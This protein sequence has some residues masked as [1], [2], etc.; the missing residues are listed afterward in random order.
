MNRMSFPGLQSPAP[1]PP[2]PTSNSLNGLQDDESGSPSGMIKNHSIKVKA[3][4]SSS[5]FI[6]CLLTST[7]HHSQTQPDGASPLDSAGQRTFLFAESLRGGRA[8]CRLRCPTRTLL[9]SEL[10]IGIFSFLFCAK[11][12]AQPLPANTIQD[13]A[14]LQLE[15]R[16]QQRRLCLRKGEKGS[17]AGFHLLT[18]F[19]CLRTSQWSSVCF[20][21]HPI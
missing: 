7:Q 4:V 18:N 17:R 1:Q 11:T 21:S 16:Y 14:L 2:M 8:S 5:F 10:S 19:L 13:E 3:G 9:L 12:L 15:G 20:G 6:L